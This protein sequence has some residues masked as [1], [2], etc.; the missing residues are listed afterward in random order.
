MRDSY[1]FKPVPIPEQ[2]KFEEHRLRQLDIIELF[3]GIKTSRKLLADNATK[4]IADKLAPIPKD[5]LADDSEE[6]KRVGEIHVALHAYEQTYLH[7]GGDWGRFQGA[8]KLRYPKTVELV[9]L[10]DKH[11]LYF[12][13]K[14]NGLRV[15]VG[16]IHVND[17]RFELL[18]E[19]PEGRLVDVYQRIGKPGRHYIKLSTSDTFVRRF[20][21][22]G[23]NASDC[24]ALDS[25]QPLTAA[26][27]DQRVSMP[28]MNKVDLGLNNRYSYTKGHVLSV[29]EQILSHTRGWQKRFISTG[30]SPNRPAYSTRGTVFVSMY[31]TAYIDLAF[32]PNDSIYDVH[33]PDTSGNRLGIESKD[34]TTRDT[35]YPAKN[36]ADEKYLAL[37]DTIRTRELLIKGSIPNNAVKKVSEGLRILGICYIEARDYEAHKS[38]GGLRVTKLSTVNG[39]I[40]EDENLT[41]QIRGRYWHFFAFDS[42]VACQTGFDLLDTIPVGTALSCK[43]KTRVVKMKLN[44]YRHVVSPGAD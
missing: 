25:A 26:Y 36:H 35:A 43:G 39:H 9:K 30:V 32:V 6:K 33:R 3:T 20:V 14:F 44:R 8:L 38:H 19:Q 31:G 12:T 24:M 17:Q 21:F 22:R 5:Q 27:T 2:P 11:E 42:I 23:L 29:D 40:T 34:L 16:T 7:I 41:F 1:L 10:S 18:P 37:R 4:E 13:S 28:E 15:L